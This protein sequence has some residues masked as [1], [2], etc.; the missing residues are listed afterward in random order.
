[1]T[2]PDNIIIDGTEQVNYKPKALI[3]RSATKRS[4]NLRHYSV[5]IQY[6]TVPPNKGSVTSWWNISMMWL[7]VWWC[8]S[9][10]GPIVAGG[11][12][13]DSTQSDDVAW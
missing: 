9:V 12:Q 13:Q 8:R 6:N 5:H 1:M 4:C 10:K 7:I 2:A 3:H 11:H